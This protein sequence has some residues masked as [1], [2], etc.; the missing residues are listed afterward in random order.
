MKKDIWKKGWL[1]EILEQAEKEV[2]SWPEWMKQP[3]M[4]Y[5]M[6]RHRIKEECMKQEYPIVI[7]HVIDDKESYYYAFLPDFGHSACSACGD[8]IEEAIELLGKVKSDIVDF[9]KEKGKEIPEPT[10]LPL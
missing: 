5:P 3:E 4:R 7:H 9:Y 2:E 8:S 6:D 10:I 1:D